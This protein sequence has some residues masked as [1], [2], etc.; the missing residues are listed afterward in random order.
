MGWV[1][2]FEALGPLAVISDQG[3]V[4]LRPAHR[5]LLASL[6][7]NH[8]VPV[9][10]DTLIERMWGE[11]APATANNTLHVHLS[12]L[13]RHVPGL[14][15]AA[16]D[17][18]V[19]VANGHG[20]D[21]R[22]F[23]GLAER[24]SRRL[25]KGRFREAGD[26][27]NRASKLWRGDPF[28]ELIDVDAARGERQR[29][30]ELLTSTKITLAKALT[31]QGRV[32]ESIA[33]LKQLVVDHSFNEL[34]WEELILA[35]Y[36]AGRQADALAAFQE[37][38]RTLVEELG[39]DPGPRLQELEDRILL[40]DP[41]LIRNRRNHV[42]NNLVSPTNSFIGR[43]HDLDMVA[44]LLEEHR[45]VTIT[46][47]PGVG[48]TRLALESAHALLD[49]YSGGV[50][51]IRLVGASSASDLLATV[52]A[53]TEANTGGSLE[54]LGAALGSRPC[55]FV[56]DNCEHLVEE[57]S[58]LTRSSLSMSGPV[59]LLLTSRNPI[60]VNGEVLWRLD[61]LPVPGDE[62]VQTPLHNPT[63][64]LF[65]DRVLDLD[66]SFEVNAATV[67]D[68]VALC[69]RTAGIP[70]ALELAAG[71]VPALSLQDVVEVANRPPPNTVRSDTPHHGSLG[72]AVDWS[73]GLLKPEDRQ[74]LIAATVFAGDFDLAAF[75]AVC[76]PG[77]NVTRTA[78]TIS[79]LV[80]ASLVVADRSSSGALRYRILEPIRDYCQEYVDDPLGLR[81]RHAAWF[82]ERCDEHDSLAGGPEE[83]ASFQTI[84]IEI[85]DFRAA[86]RH[87]IDSG[88]H[89]DAARMAT[90]LSEYWFARYLGWE[91]TNWLD[92]ILSGAIEPALRVGALCAAGWAAYTR[93]AYPLARARYTEARD[94][95]QQT[96][97][98][99]GEGDAWYGLARVETG[100]NPDGWKPIIDKAVE[101]YESVDATEIELVKCY[102]WVALDA[103]NRGERAR[104][105]TLY[106]KVIEVSERRSMSRS[107][108][109]AHTYLS[110]AAMLDEDEQGAMEHIAK[111]EAIA[112]KAEEMPALYSALHQRALVEA[113]WGRVDRAASGLVEALVMT[114]V[115][116]GNYLWMY[117]ANALGIMIRM[118]DWDRGAWLMA[119]INQTYELNGW[120]AIAPRRHAYAWFRDRITE[121]VPVPV[122]ANEDLMSVSEVRDEVVDWLRT[123]A[124]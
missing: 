81:D 111:A 4:Q 80:S 118:E 114:P 97:D 20:L 72:T 102:A 61:P 35:Y 105:E 24:A 29:L 75:H 76:L 101:V 123:L 95:A 18:Y 22:E 77:A 26:M 58:V 99:K 71:W 100:T 110:V 46:G 117:L 115:A 55:L 51:W 87:L 50:W 40:Q 67:R 45:M 60:G 120:P 21:V 65:V 30:I 19:L 103:C 74:T 9:P 48:K 122:I 85:A 49:R 32:S 64:R 73:L 27:A 10:T 6:L 54:D 17:G 89:N 70:L 3:P 93:A 69:G 109:M 113:R 14:I 34:L 38:R 37:A 12:T 2:R 52:A 7:L 106:A 16:G 11:S 98:R 41:V 59:R 108:S 84:D 53:V 63:V 23:S 25:G 78:Q 5:R 119:T 39:V 91:A 121:H 86:L 92:E 33:V 1:M 42:P 43:E 57:V 8:D 79:A 31:L 47:A 56:L 94:L 13:R 82:I 116:H 112:R 96:G 62:D 66:P 15:Q 88:R 104:A 83:A 28:P 124:E 36:L 68:L 107:V 90:M 44:K